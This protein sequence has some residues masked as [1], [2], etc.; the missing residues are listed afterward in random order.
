MTLGFI[1]RAVEKHREDLDSILLCLV[2]IVAKKSK[3]V[4]IMQSLARWINVKSR[5]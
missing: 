2:G 5:V 1:Q 3:C 4:I